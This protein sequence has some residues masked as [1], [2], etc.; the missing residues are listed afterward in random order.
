MREGRESWERGRRGS[1]DGNGENSLRWTAAARFKAALFEIETERYGDRD[2]HPYSIPRHV[3]MPVT[4]LYRRAA[5]MSAPPMMAVSATM[6][7]VTMM[8]STTRATQ[9]R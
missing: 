2:L 7:T 8:E 5:M 1:G 4:S 9:V 3:R 6:A